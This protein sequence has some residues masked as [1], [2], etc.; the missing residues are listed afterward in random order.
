MPG[1]STQASAAP[2]WPIG[3]LLESEVDDLVEEVRGAGHLTF[4]RRLGDW[5]VVET[6]RDDT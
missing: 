5:Y 6:T 2:L 3:V 4:A 1:Q